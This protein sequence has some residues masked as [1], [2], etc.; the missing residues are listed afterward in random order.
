M[1]IKHKQQPYHEHA[2]DFFYPANDR[3][4]VLKSVIEYKVDM[5][6]K[7][8]VYDVAFS[9]RIVFFFVGVQASLRCESGNRE[10]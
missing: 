9:F 4:V 3:G 10:E 6:G 5:E 8:T 2:D 1:T 7:N